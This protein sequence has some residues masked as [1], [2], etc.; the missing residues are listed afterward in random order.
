MDAPLVPRVL[1]LRHGGD[2]KPDWRTKPAWAGDEDV[3]GVC[4]T[5]GGG[6]FLEWWAGRTGA[7]ERPPATLPARPGPGSDSVAGARAAAAHIHDAAGGWRS[8][9]SLPNQIDATAELIAGTDRLTSTAFRGAVPI[10]AGRA[11]LLGQEAV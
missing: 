10:R 9:L 2:R 4:H 3:A 8:Y 1:D 7:E 5:A 6:L 11:A